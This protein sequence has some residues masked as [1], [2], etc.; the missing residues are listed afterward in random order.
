M[1]N[2]FNRFARDL[3]AQLDNLVFLFESAEQQ[4][5]AQIAYINLE[6]DR[7]SEFGVA[8]SS[9]GSAILIL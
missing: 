1:E 7:A 4:L 6:T 3:K 8:F 5:V 9:D 2:V